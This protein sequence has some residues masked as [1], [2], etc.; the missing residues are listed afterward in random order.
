MHAMKKFFNYIALFG[1]C[2]ITKVNM[3]GE[4]SDWQKLRDKVK[5]MSL[6]VNV[7]WVN[8]LLIIIDNFILTFNDKP[9]IE[10]W[11]NI[12]YLKIIMV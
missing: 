4:E 6:F 2:G 3:L 12:C 5:N 7:E 10:F 9:N 11:V 1:G 8:K